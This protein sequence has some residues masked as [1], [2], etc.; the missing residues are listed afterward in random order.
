MAFTLECREVTHKVWLNHYLGLAQATDEIL[1]IKVDQQALFK[2]LIG[3]V[4]PG[5]STSYRIIEDSD[6]KGVFYITTPEAITRPFAILDADRNVIEFR[7]EVSKRNK[8]FDSDD[9]PLNEFIQTF[10]KSYN[11]DTPLEF[12]VPEIVDGQ[13][14]FTHRDKSGYE[15]KFWGDK[16]TAESNLIADAYTGSF[17]LKKIKSESERNSKFK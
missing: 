11:I 2:S 14:C 16:M 10:I 6:K 8:I 12:S 13:A 1:T 17:W 4:I 3:S 9:T 15:L 5:A 7:V